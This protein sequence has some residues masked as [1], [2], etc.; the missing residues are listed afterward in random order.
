MDSDDKSSD[1]DTLT[2]RQE[3][4]LDLAKNA[5]KEIR[6]CN[7]TEPTTDDVFYNVILLMKLAKKFTD[8]SNISLLDIRPA[9]SFLTE[10]FRKNE[11]AFGR[12][13]TLSDQ[14]E[15][16]FKLLDDTGTAIWT[17]AQSYEDCLFR[18][19]FWF[20]NIQDPSED[21]MD[22]LQ[23]TF[24][25]TEIDSFLS[26]VQSE[27]KKLVSKT[28]NKAVCQATAY[29]NLCCKIA[30]LH[31]FVLWQAFCIMN[32]SALYQPG[33]RVVLDMI[34]HSQSSNLNM[35]KCITEPEIQNAVFLSVFNITE[36]ENV[37]HFLQI[38]EIVT[39][40]DK[41]FYEQTYKIQWVHSPDVHLKWNDKTETFCGS[42]KHIDK[43]QFQYI[44]GREFDNVCYIWN[45]SRSG[46]SYIG[47]GKD[48]YCRENSKKSKWKLISF[49][50]DGKNRSFIVAS[51]VWPDRFLYLN[52]AEGSV[53]CRENRKEDAKYVRKALW[54]ILKV[55]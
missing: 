39:H 27:V 8:N 18:A 25:I 11:C 48:G 15:K 33:T 23:N 41:R 43:F 1:G 5:V 2:E 51:A 40:L 26:T 6:K 46:N 21:L 54:N 53:T 3:Q 16:Y 38:Q 29:V 52:S 19:N 44:E 55:E 28:E 22:K 37:K 36:N 14:Q 42:T 30:I 50:K 10:V 17:R 31:S 4:A 35:L 34:N 49:G 45:V 9:C 13:K 7:N 24:T 12:I 47:F 32:R 20:A